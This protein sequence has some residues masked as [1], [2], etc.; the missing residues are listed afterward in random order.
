[1]GGWF[2]FFWLH[3]WHVELLGQRWKLSCC[4]I[5]CSLIHCATRE[6][7]KNGFYQ[8]LI[9]WLSN[10][11]ELIRYISNYILNTYYLSGILSRWFIFNGEWNTTSAFVELCWWAWREWRGNSVTDTDK[12]ICVCSLF[13]NAVLKKSSEGVPVVT[14]WLTN[15]ARSHEV[16]GSIPALAQF[17]KDPALP[18][19]VVWVTDVAQVPHCCGSGVDQW[20]QLRLDPSLRTSI[21]CRSSSRN[22]KR[23]KGRQWGVLVSG[24]RSD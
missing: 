18:W 24:N 3:P 19:A 17:V 12:Q 7:Q 9:Q 4:D 21:C 1:M 13:K 8:C 15:P 22:G 16:A 14:Q 10:F 6:L 2:F 20:L 23:Q 5:A 11:K